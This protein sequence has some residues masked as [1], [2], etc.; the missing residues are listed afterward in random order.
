MVLRLGD[1]LDKASLP[2]RM[3]SLNVNCCSGDSV[4]IPLQMRSLITLRSVF[5][6]LNSLRNLFFAALNKYDLTCFMLTACTRLSQILINTSC[7][8]SSHKASS[9]HKLLINGYSTGV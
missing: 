9:L 5:C 6:F 1:S 7:T 3:P 4:S 8:I 2:K